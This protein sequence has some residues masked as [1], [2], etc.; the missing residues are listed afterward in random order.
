M[1]DAQPLCFRLTGDIGTADDTMQDSV[2]AFLEFVTSTTPF[3]FQ[4]GF[5][6]APRMNRTGLAFAA[7]LGVVLFLV[8]QFTVFAVIILFAYTQLAAPYRRCARS[9][10]R[11]EEKRVVA[12][13]LEF[14]GHFLH[15]LVH[16]RAFCAQSRYE[17]QLFK[18]VDNAQTYDHWYVPRHII[19][20][21]VLTI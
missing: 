16:I 5:L 19:W 18:R 7:S 1:V 13:L 14:S 6:V 2:R 11:L 4:L 20:S 17:S 8:P 21:K 9:M 15:G 10:R 12:P 3:E